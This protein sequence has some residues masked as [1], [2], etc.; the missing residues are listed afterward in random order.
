MHLF[1][2]AP[3]GHGPTKPNPARSLLPV[4]PQQ[5]QLATG[6]TDPVVPWR[7]MPWSPRTQAISNRMRPCIATLGGRAF[8][9]KK[10][11]AG[12]D[13][14]GWSPCAFAR[15]DGHRHASDA[16]AESQDD[17]PHCA[18]GLYF[19]SWKRMSVRRP[20]MRGLGSTAEGRCSGKGNIEAIGAASRPIRQ[21][22]CV[23]GGDA[24]Q[25]AGSG[26]SKRDGPHGAPAGRPWHCAGCSECGA[27]LKVGKPPAAYPTI[28]STMSVPSL[29]CP[30][31]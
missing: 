19:R 1:L 27:I 26:T 4:G 22:F 3:G 13:R 25:V 16:W 10:C 5:D 31:S 7:S 18:R 12:A 20:W 11:H 15:A 9:D 17:P 30:R 23:I 8:E 24:P 28:R 2:V 21:R 14:P 29:D 6:G